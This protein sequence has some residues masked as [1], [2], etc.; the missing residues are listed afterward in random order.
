MSGAGGAASSEE[1][2]LPVAKP[3]AALAARASATQTGARLIS[4]FPEGSRSSRGF[5][6]AGGRGSAG[7]SSRIGA[8]LG[9]AAGLGALFGRRCLR[10]SR[11][12]GISTCVP[13][14]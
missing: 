4:G 8:G 12:T 1:P 9:A 10:G 6:G 3:A 5:A 2:T 11:T 14:A 13:R 7:R